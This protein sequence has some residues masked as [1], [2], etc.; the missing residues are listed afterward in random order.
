MRAKIASVDRIVSTAVFAAHIAKRTKG[1]S[2]PNM[3]CYPQAYG[4]VD[5]RGETAGRGGDGKPL[6]HGQRKRGLLRRSGEGAKVDPTRP[7]RQ[8]SATEGGRTGMTRK[9]DPHSVIDA[10]RQQAAD[11][12]R[13]AEVEK[14]PETSK[15]LKGLARS[16]MKI[17]GIVFERLRTG[18]MTLNS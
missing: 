17:A 9:S 1:Y 13:Q 5:T 7:P 18:A 15:A 4:K 11:C 16:Y 3:A 2:R 12:I 10:L 6:P 8:S 14:Q